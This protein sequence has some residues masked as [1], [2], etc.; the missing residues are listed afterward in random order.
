MPRYA[1]SE[2]DWPHRHW[3]LFLE[4][5]D[6]LRT[7]RLLARPDHEATIPAVFTFPHRRIYLDYSGAISQNRG[8][9]TRWDTGEFCW[10]EDS[11][12]RVLIRLVGE[13]WQGTLELRHLAGEDWQAI[14]S[15]WLTDSVPQSPQAEPGE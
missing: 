3:D 8:Q 12:E 14:A 4:D 6:A 10:V 5:G 13:Q 11:P 7:W 2:H 15:P 1:I 9:I